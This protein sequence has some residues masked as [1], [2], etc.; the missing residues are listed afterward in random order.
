M[1]AAPP[2]LVIV[3]DDVALR[4]VF[5]KVL[6]RAGYEVSTATGNP[7][8]VAMVDEQ[9]PA[10]VLMDNHMPGTSGLD[11]ITLLRRRWSQNSL[12]ILLI[13]GSSNQEE[14]D[15][16]MRSGAND[17]RRKPVELLDLLS[18]VRALL[19]PSATQVTRTSP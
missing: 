11:L 5:A 6:T 15:A 8:V 3:D 16:A 17:F 1:I 2:R 7:D 13:S 14:I 18:A 19:E 10:A 4:T 12:P 9:A